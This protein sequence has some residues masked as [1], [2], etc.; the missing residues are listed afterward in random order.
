V[1]QDLIAFANQ[2]PRLEMGDEAGGWVRRHIADLAE[3]YQASAKTGKLDV[4]EVERLVDET[5][6]AGEKLNVRYFAARILE[7]KGETRR[8]GRCWRRARRVETCMGEARIR[9]KI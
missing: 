7:L 2:N 1:I 6:T 9:P 4:G 5:P 3:L 8:P